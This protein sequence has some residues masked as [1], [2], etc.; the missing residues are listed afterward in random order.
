MN[1]I[2][3]NDSFVRVDLT[4]QPIG[5]VCEQCL[6]DGCRHIHSQVTVVY[7]NHNLR[8]AIKS[9]NREWVIRS[10]VEKHVFEETFAR[11]IFARS[12]WGEIKRDMRKIQIALDKKTEQMNQKLALVELKN[13]TKH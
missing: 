11:L 9:P 12:L 3:E 10:G 1:E 5:G 8:C 7:C 2:V 4:G 6:K 13:E